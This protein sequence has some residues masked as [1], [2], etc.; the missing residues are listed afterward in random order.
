MNCIT[1]HVPTIIAKNSFKIF[2]LNIKNN[3]IIAYNVPS[4]NSVLIALN[5]LL[6]VKYDTIWTIPTSAI[7]TPITI[8]IKLSDAS[9][10]KIKNIE[11]IISNI[12]VAIDVFS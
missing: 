9:G 10:L 1:S 4:I 12:E 8:T 11:N 6:D 5:S 2:G 3:P 7:N